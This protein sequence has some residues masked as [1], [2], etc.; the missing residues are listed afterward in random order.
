[1]R[2]LLAF[3]SIVSMLISEHSSLLSQHSVPS[4]SR[5]LPATELQGD[6]EYKRHRIGFGTSI[7]AGDLTTGQPGIMV[8]SSYSYALSPVIALEASLHTINHSVFGED[9]Q[10]LTVP[11]TFALIS[12]SWTFDGIISLSPVDRWS[13]FRIDIGPSIRWQNSSYT[14]LVNGVRVEVRSQTTIALG[15]TMKFDYALPIHPKFELLARLQG[16]L[17]ALP[18]LG[19]NRHVPSGVPGITLSAGLFLRIL[20]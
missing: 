16:H 5:I 18:F 2:L 8:S 12:S 9:V 1:M 13:T 19:E 3:V 11:Y 17:L 15:G 4:S 10:V 6:V 14:A 20:W 7:T